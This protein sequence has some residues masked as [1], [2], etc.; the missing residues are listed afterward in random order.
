MVKFIGF[1]IQPNKIIGFIFDVEDSKKESTSVR[2][3][4]NSNYCISF[5][6]F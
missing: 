4:R 2:E 1:I 6:A 5:D 3:K